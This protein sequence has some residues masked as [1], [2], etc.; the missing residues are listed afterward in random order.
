MHVSD[1][2]VCACVRVQVWFQNRRAKWRKRE[3]PVQS[4][5]SAAAALHVFRSFQLPHYHSVMSAAATSSGL[6][7]PPIGLR[8]TPTGLLATPTRL[9]APP[10][11]NA[12][13]SLIGQK[14]SRRSDR[15]NRRETA[16]QLRSPSKSH[17][18]KPPIEC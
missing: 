11:F 16:S 4:L 1:R 14:A 9:L 12:P 6:L 7:A 15:D 3:R 18:H 2:S 8:A 13:P 10:T 5:F 17:I